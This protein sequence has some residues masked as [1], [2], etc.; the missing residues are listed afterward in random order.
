MVLG[1]CVLSGNDPA[2]D[3]ADCAN[4]FGKTDEAGGRLQTRTRAQWMKLIR[5][6]VP[7][8]VRTNEQGELLG[9]NPPIVAVRASESAIEV[10]EAGIDWPG[11]QPEWRPRPFA[12]AMLDTPASEVAE[13]IA[14]AW[15]KRLSRYRWCPRCRR[16]TQPEH[17]LESKVGVCHGCATKHLGI[18]F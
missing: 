3:C 12:T 10:L 14:G 8:P 13:L 9:G 11:V 16:M 18:V 5:A 1:G 2:W 4:R 7:K 15:G 17:M 6:M